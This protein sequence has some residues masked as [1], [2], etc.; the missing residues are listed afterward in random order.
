[1]VVSCAR[2]CLKAP[3]RSDF[4]LNRGLG[5]NV[6]GGCSP[7]ISRFGRA[8]WLVVGGVFSVWRSDFSF[9]LGVGVPT[10]PTRNLSEPPSGLVPWAR[11]LIRPWFYMISNPAI[12]TRVCRLFLQALYIME[13]RIFCLF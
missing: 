8:G 4:S 10:R 11:A 1:M 3:G 13:K 2:P 6:A 12:L 9:S 5:G 7:P